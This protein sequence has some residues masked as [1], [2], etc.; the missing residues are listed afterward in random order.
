[1]AVLIASDLAKD[2]AGEPLLRGVSFKLERRDRMTIAGRNGAGKTTLLR[3]LAGEASIDGGELVLQKGARVAL[4]DQRPPRERDLTLREYVT[5]GAKDIVEMEEDLRRMEEE[6]AAGST[7]PALYDRYARRQSEFELRGGYTWR[8]YALSVLRNLGFADADVD[9]PLHTFSGGQL[10][11]AS[12]ARALASQPDLLLLDE[13]TNH[14]DIDSLEWLESELKQ[15][16]AAIVMVAHDRWFLES[17]GT[18]VLEIEAGRA[19]FFPGTWHQWRK[20]AAARELALGRAIAKQQAEIARMERFI[21]RFRAKATKARQVQSR[22]KRLEKMERL[23][24]EPRDTREMALSFGRAERSGRVVFE[25]I[26]G[27]LEIPGDPPKVLLHGANMWLERGEHVTLVG[28]NG[29]GKTTLIKALT[30]QRPLDGGRLS[31]GHNVKIGYLSQH[32]EELGEVGSVLDVTQRLTGLSPN[33]ARALLGRFLFSGREAEKPIAG[34]SGGE[35]RRVSLAVLVAGG[36]NVLI[37]D[38]PT[39]HLD[40]ESREALED[41]LREFEGA[42]LLVSH[43]RALLDAVGTR[44]IAIERGTLRSYEGGWAEYQ[45]IREERRAAGEDVDGPAPQD[46]RPPADPNARTPDGRAATGR[47]GRSGRRGKPKPSGPSKNALRREEELAA[48]VEAAEAAL[49]ALEQEL[50]DPARWATPY[51]SAKSEARL[52][53]ARRAVDEAYAAWEAHAAKVQA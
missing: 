37:L 18:S 50:A 33:K 32:A 39:N 12:L 13:P 53:A 41:A 38:E 30:G 28:A 36:A 49:A 3:M 6:M 4:H 31:I 7:D 40:L 11:R 52:T 8:E 1:V 16:D 45:R 14:L 20:E 5:S 48:A 29:T 24:R 25:L 17:V 47:S 34:L 23:E 46:V 51:E 27:H 21:A 9:R 42:V 19:R 35:R 10:T 43:D 15:L 44:T 26:D 2:M 22:V